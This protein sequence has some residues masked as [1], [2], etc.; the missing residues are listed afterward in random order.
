MTAQLEGEMANLDWEQVLTSRDSVLECAS[1]M[2]L[3]N[4]GGASAKVEAAIEATAPE[5]SAPYKYQKPRKP[6][7]G[8][9]PGSPSPL[10]S[11]LGRG[12]VLAPYSAI[13]RAL[14]HREMRNGSPSP[15]G[16][17]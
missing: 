14:L 15:Q 8:R 16:R 13:A 5:D 9:M 3:W 1:P 12:G 7:L 4:L 10:P 17:G 2:A 11:P 6:I